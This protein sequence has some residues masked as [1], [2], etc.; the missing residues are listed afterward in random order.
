MPGRPHHA[1]DRERDAAANPRRLATATAL[2][3]ASPAALP[4]PFDELS[5]SDGGKVTPVNSDIRPQGEGSGQEEKAAVSIAPPN[6]I[7]A[8]FR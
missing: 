8:L 5:A 1:R 4:V 2:P 7:C 6:R 3:V